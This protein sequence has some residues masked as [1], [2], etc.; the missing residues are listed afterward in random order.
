MMDT[1]M[2]PCPS[3]SYNNMASMN[4]AITPRI[5]ATSTINPIVI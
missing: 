2:N 3:K 1:D 5:F 4:A